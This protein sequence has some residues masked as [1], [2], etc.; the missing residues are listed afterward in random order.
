M[1]HDD[2]HLESVN[3]R[4]FDLLNVLRYDR[5]FGFKDFDW[6]DRMNISRER[7]ALQSFKN[8]LFREIAHEQINWYTVT[9]PLGAKIATILKKIETENWQH[10]P[11]KNEPE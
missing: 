1:E 2:Y 11:S 8:Y 10:K 6:I 4:M 5:A 7:S 3:D 9:K